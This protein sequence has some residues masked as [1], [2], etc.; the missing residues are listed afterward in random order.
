M[1]QRLYE[2]VNIKGEHTALIS[3]PRTDSIRIS[4]NFIGK[5]KQFIIKKYGEEYYQERTFANKNNAQNTQDAHEA[6]RVID[7]TVTPD[8][9]KSI[10]SRD[11]YKLYKLI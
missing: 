1:A 3:Y 4:D 10:I 6:I 2:G 11:E 8:S 5:L 9:L 7:P